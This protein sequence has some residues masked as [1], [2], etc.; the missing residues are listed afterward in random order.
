MFFDLCFAFIVIGVW[1]L[2][3]GGAVAAEQNG[4]IPYA[5]AL[6]HSPHTGDR[7]HAWWMWV[8]FALCG[9]ITACMLLA[10]G[11]VLNRWRRREAQVK[12]FS[13]FLKKM[14]GR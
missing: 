1:V 8:G 4:L 13:E 5:A 14:F 3:M 2:V 9:T 6:V 11:Y 10:F 7:I 12:E